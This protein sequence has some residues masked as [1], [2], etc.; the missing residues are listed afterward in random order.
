MSYQVTDTKAEA[1]RF[2]VTRPGESAPSFYVNTEQQ[3]RDV[4][5]IDKQQLIGE[6]QLMRCPECSAE[7][8]PCIAS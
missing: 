1:M 3:A 5:E 4:I 8:C 7:H 2:H 6:S